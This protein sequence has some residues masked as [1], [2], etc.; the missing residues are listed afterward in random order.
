MYDDTPDGIIGNED[1]GQM[2]AWY[3]MSSLG[4]YSVCP[5]TGEYVLTTPLFDE[6]E[7]IMANGKVLTIK[8]NNPA[9]NRY[10]KSVTLNGRPLT[11]TFITY[12]QLLE[13]G[14]LEYELSREPVKD[15][16]LELPYSLSTGEE[17]S[18][19][20]TTSEFSL[21][22]DSVDFT[23]GTTTPDAEI[24]YT[25]DGSEPDSSSMLYDG[26]IRLDASTVVSART[27][28]EA[29]ARA[30]LSGSMPK[31]RSSSR[32]SR[33]PDLH[34]ESVTVSTTEDSH[35]WPECACPK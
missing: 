8:A 2:S 25:L 20:Y 13:G 6:A 34:R 35:P 15:I 32:G 28:R 5:G 9:R 31:R 14:V 12:A 17:A 16:D 18:V 19:P 29:S 4:F 7:M 26:A 27:F 24:R 23:L 22:I 21:F 3:V 11:T 1:C 33:S 10:I 30:G